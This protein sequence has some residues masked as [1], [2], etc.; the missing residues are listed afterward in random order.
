[1]AWLE[2]VLGDPILWYDIAQANVDGTVNLHFPDEVMFV[3]KVYEK[4]A[5]NTGRACALYG[6][7]CASR[8]GDGAQMGRGDGLGLHYH[9]TARNSEAVSSANL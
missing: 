1:M 9:S 2:P 8:G 7:V 4:P 6:Y 5:L 3:T